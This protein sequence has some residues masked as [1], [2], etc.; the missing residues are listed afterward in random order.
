MKGKTARII[1]T[2]DTPVWFYH[3]IYKSPGIN[4]LKKSILQFCGLKQIRITIFA[5]VKSSEE[6]KR[7]KW[8]KKIELMGKDMK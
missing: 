6:M 8:L 1:T 5:T 3:L 7:K 2:M 4:S